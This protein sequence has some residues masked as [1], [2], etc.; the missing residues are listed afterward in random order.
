[1]SKQKYV[2]RGVF[3][4]QLKDKFTL[5]REGYVK[6]PDYIGDILDIIEDAIRAERKAKHGIKKE[7][8]EL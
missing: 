5:N 3:K 4:D 2:W 1:M 6:Y 7:K 8:G